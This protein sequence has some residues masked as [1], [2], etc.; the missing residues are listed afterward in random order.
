MLAR[1]PPF[2]STAPALVAADVKGPSGLSAAALS[3][4]IGVSPSSPSLVAVVQATVSAELDWTP[5]AE[6]QLSCPEIAALQES[7]GLQ[8]RALPLEDLP[9]G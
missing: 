6:S 7:S 5:I 1:V 8:F 2:P 3:A 4:G 9:G